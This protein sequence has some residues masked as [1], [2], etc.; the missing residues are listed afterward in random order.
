M[1]A[2]QIQSKHIKE[3]ETSPQESEREE[4]FESER[5]ISHITLRKY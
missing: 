3:R 2:I 4:S 5:E 1:Q